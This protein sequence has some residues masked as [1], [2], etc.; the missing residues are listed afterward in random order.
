MSELQENV[1]QI[2]N[3]CLGFLIRLFFVSLPIQRVVGGLL[4]EMI[5]AGEKKNYREWKDV[6][7]ALM[8]FSFPQP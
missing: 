8:P 5:Y 7:S 6:L 3:G 1:L 4:R 2:F